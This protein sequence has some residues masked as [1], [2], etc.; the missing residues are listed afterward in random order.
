M[1]CMQFYLTD[2]S[3]LVESITD[4]RTKAFCIIVEFGMITVDAC[5]SSGQNNEH[6]A[7][8][9]IANNTRISRFLKESEHRN[10]NSSSRNL[11]SSR[12]KSVPHVPNCCTPLLRKSKYLNCCSKLWDGLVNKMPPSDSPTLDP[13]VTDGQIDRRRVCVN[14][15]GKRYETFESTLAK[16]PETL[17]ALPQRELFFDSL[18]GEYFFDRNRKAFGAI[19]TYCQTGVLVKPANLDDRI[20]AAELRFFGFEAESEAHVP[21]AQNQLDDSLLP[22][23]KYLKQVWLLF[24]APDTSLT[25]R[26]VSLFSMSVILLSI[27]MFCIETLPEFKDPVY[28]INPQTGKS[29]LS[30][31]R[32]KVAYESA[33]FAIE[34]GCIMWFTTEYLLR[35][36]SSPK[37]WM[38]LHQPLNLID[39]VAIVPFYVT[40]FLHST[41]SSVSSFSILRVLRLIRVFRIFKLSRYSKGLK[42]LGYTFRVGSIHFYF[43]IIC[44]CYHEFFVLCGLQMF[45][46]FERFFLHV[47][48]ACKKQ[49]LSESIS[50]FYVKKKKIIRSYVCISYV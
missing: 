27:V 7:T 28:T 40:I 17:L 35:F 1:N 42:I 4:K 10:L 23:N 18:N 30:S 38:F 44:Y 6:S 8:P 2:M 47:K 9:L 11:A 20:F 50:S 5:V 49:H 37:K 31:F 45:V 48:F 25:A 14:I 26:L 12:K 43:L 46:F 39:I 41:N 29:S 36:I 19:L 3:F 21:P 13:I 32:T 34:C 15:S 16:Y 22:T 33:F 24:E